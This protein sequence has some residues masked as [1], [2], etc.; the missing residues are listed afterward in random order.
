MIMN[1]Q[2]IAYTNAL[3]SHQADALTSTHS[4]KFCETVGLTGMAR[5]TWKGSLYVLVNRSALLSFKQVKIRTSY[6]SIALLAREA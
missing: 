1:L 4:P 5:Y 3:S 6:P 2:R